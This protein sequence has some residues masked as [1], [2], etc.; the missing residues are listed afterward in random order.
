MSTVLICVSIA[1][2]IYLIY[3]GAALRIFG[4]P[5]S[6]SDTFYL[7]NEKKK[8]LGIL[9]P[10]MMVSMAG[11][12]LP[13]WLE[14]SALSSL[15]FTAFLAAAGII[16]TG[17]A[18]AFKSNDLEKRVHIGSALTAAVF[19]LLWVIFVS[20]LWFTIIIWFAVILLI[21]FITKTIKSS[22]I[23]WLETVAFM[24]TFTSIL[25]FLLA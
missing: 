15:Q 9:F 2:I 8:H 17:S 25:F 24:S 14:I 10:I 21:A 22:Y 13:A 11:L 18:P 7:Y 5:E 1:F 20:K 23:Y 16:F 4:I 12:L 19:A 6:L 3:N